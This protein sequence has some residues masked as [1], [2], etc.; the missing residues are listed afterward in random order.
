MRFHASIRLDLRRIQAIK[1][2]GEV[3]GA[4]IRAT[5][6]KNKVAPPYR[7]AEFDILFED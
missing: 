4:R 5:V 3:I 1:S 6:K 2:K 7:S